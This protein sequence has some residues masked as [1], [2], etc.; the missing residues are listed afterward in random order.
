MG[1]CKDEEKLNKI[2]E[3][4]IETIF[5]NPYFMHSDNRWI[6][7]YGD[8]GERETIDAVDVIA[9]L[10]EASHISVTK[11]PYSYMFHCANK[12]GSWVEDDLFDDIIYGDKD[13]KD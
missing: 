4:L 7:I 3:W 10:Y 2:R 13:N 11:E 5:R 1:E 6:E 12:V 8:Q 9:S